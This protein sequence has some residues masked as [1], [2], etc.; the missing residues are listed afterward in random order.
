MLD[1]KLEEEQW[2]LMF[3][4]SKTGGW[5]LLREAL[6]HNILSHVHKKH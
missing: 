1:N 5:I 3:F 2:V 4:F 6:R